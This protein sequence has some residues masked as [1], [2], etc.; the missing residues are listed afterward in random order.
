MTTLTYE[1][2]AGEGAGSGG[3]DSTPPVQRLV[4]LARKSYRDGICAADDPVIRDAIVLQAIVAEGIRQ[5]GRRAR[6][7]A[8]IEHPMRL[9]L[10]G[11]LT[12]SEFSQQNARLGVDI[13][14]AA[15]TLYK[16]D[17]AAPD[18]GRWPLAYMAS[19]GGTIAAGTSEIQRNILG[20]RVLGLAKSK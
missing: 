15:S 19:Y 12:G 20:E 16:L 8:L 1:R 17:P 18:E 6:V 7:P 14:G 4:E 2:G 5:N 11:K 3:G 10:Q 9:P 13:A